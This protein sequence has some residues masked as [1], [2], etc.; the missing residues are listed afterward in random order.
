MSKRDREIAPRLQGVCVGWGCVA[1]VFRAMGIID[2][3]GMGAVISGGLLS[4]LVSLWLEEEERETAWVVM[5]VAG[6]AAWLVGAGVFMAAYGLWPWVKGL[7][8][9]G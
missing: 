8:L 1:I 2:W 6:V 7:I 4:V 5:L 3:A 9:G